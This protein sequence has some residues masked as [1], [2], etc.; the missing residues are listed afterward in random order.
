V[1]SAARIVTIVGGGAY[2]PTLCEVLAR[3]PLAGRHRIRLAARRSDRLAIVAAHASARV[4]AIRPHDGWTVTACRDN[5][6]AIDGADDVV[7]L[8]RVG[9]SAARAHDERFP[10]EF[11]LVGDEG[12][13]PG[14]IANAYR[15]VPVLVALAE[16]VRRAA[17]HARVWNLVAPLGVTTRLLLDEGLPAV[18]VCELP[19]VTLERLLAAAGADLTAARFDYAGLNHLGWFWNVRAGDVDVLARAAQLGLIDA[20]TLDRFAAAP[21]KY[22]YEVFA[23]AAAERLGL[24]RDPERAATLARVSD[25][26]LEHYRG[27]G[28]VAPESLRPTPWFDRAL[29]PMLAACAGGPPFA[30]FA[31]LRNTGGAIA[32]SLP[33]EAVVETATSIA[34]G[35]LVPRPW[36]QPPPQ[37]ERFLGQ[38][39]LA[40]A[41]AFAAARAQSPALVRRALETLPLDVPRAA[42]DGLVAR[43]VTPIVE[44]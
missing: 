42:L 40:E 15:T 2:V 38:T 13:G 43:A 31:N 18:G 6:E 28:D 24:A 20:H 33:A 36:G 34:D 12:L 27:N 35:A 32:P 37:V 22:F 10:R 17:P 26:L 14:G 23:P 7:L 41:M 4:A 16:R 11:G 30:G 1:S 5:D 8:V 9:G 21:L 3:A 44:T 39:A 19:T 25:R 29:V